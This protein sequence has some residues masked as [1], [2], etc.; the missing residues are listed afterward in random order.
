MDETVLQRKKTRFGE[1]KP[2]LFNKN[3]KISLISVQ[4]GDIYSHINKTNGGYECKKG[5][6][7]FGYLIDWLHTQCQSMREF[8][9]QS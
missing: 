8:V 2:H 7:R 4:Y 6:F 5:G 3:T 9:L 1:L